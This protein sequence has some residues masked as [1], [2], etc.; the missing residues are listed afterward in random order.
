MPTLPQAS[1]W[2]VRGA[3]NH[4]PATYRCPICGKH[5][6]AL[7]EHM[8]ITPEGDS[9]RRRH[10]HT[11]CVMAARRRGEM[12]LRDEW[13]ATQPRR[14]FWWRRLLRRAHA[15]PDTHG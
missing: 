5:L 4:K 1:W 12:V 6:A 14:D 11:A 3:S 2:T 13:L 8:L 7:T 15:G 9:T 10:A